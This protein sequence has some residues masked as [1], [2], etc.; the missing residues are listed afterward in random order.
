[1]KK[2]L[3]VLLCNLFAIAAFAQKTTISGTLTDKKTKEPMVS[4]NIVVK[5]TT[6]GTTSD[7]NGKFSIDLDLTNPVVLQISYLGYEK[8]EVSVNSSTKAVKVEL[9]TLIIPGQEVVVTSSRLSETMQQSATSIFKMTEKDI[10]EVASGDFYQGLASIQGVDISTSSMGFKAVN[11]RGFNTTAPV[12]V[13][14]TIDGMDNQAPG[15]NFAVGNLVGAND[16]DLQSVEVITGPASALYGPNAMQGVIS[17]KTKSP[18][19]YQGLSLQLKG[20]SRNMADGQFRYAKVVGK[21]KKFGFKVTGSFMRAD[22]WRATDT[23]VN[24]YGRLSTTQNL[25]SVIEKQQYDTINN[26]AQKIS[27]FV[28]LNNYL[29][30]NPVTYQGLNKRQI[31]T[32]GYME[33]DLSTTTTKSIKLGGN[34]SYKIKDN[35]MLSYDYRF[36]MGT[37]V[38]Q[39]TNRYSINDIMFQQHKLEFQSKRLLVRAYTTLEDAG[40]S[41]D[42]VFTGINISKAGIKRWVSDYI[43]AYVERVRSR[44]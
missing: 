26:D 44:Q 21:K 41:Y 25:A 39:G 10:K 14:Q 23:T 30:F 8:K 17:M 18:F 3:L 9:E 35:M 40:K 24:K 2:T 19:D 6:V 43:K 5:G 36:G 32:P 37:A 7:V 29:N 15:L 13:V 11:M 34:L 38:Y 33:Y 27:D 20:G 28:K 12:R 1:M 31:K 16:L 42:V 22:D 4:A